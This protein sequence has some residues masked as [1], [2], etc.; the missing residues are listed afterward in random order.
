MGP[1][2]IESRSRIE[3]RAPLARR[4]RG[5]ERGRGGR[6]RNRDHSE[7]LATLAD[8]SPEGTRFLVNRLIPEAGLQVDLILI[9]PAGVWVISAHQIR[10]E[11]RV[12]G[13]GPGQELWVGAFDCTDLIPQL[14]RSAA[15]VGGAV[16]ELVAYTPTS[17]AFCLTEA[18]LP[19]IRTLLVR[20]VPLCGPEAIIKRLNVPGPIDE[21]TARRLER[22]LALRF[23]AC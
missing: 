18:E 16:D 11:A 12:V 5:A 10:G 3:A 14:T 19:V 8:R 2:G 17:A 13:R 9:A 23:P 1:V 6:A 20:G 15:I 7:L 4:S 22:E 21:A